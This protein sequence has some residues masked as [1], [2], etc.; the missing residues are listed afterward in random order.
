MVLYSLMPLACST[1]RV[2]I[3]S[4]RNG[5][6]HTVDSNHT[7]C[8]Q[9]LK[10]NFVAYFLFSLETQSTIGF[11]HYQ[12]T[13]QCSGSLLILAA[14]ASVGV[15]VSVFAA[16]IVLN[17][18][19][20]P[21]KRQKLMGFS[22]RAVVG[23]RDGELCLMIGIYPINA[24]KLMVTDTSI[25][26]IFLETRIEKSQ[27]VPIKC[28]E[29][30]IKNQV[31]Q[32]G[33]LIMCPIIVE[34]VID[35][36]SPLYKFLPHRG[37]LSRTFEVIV[38]IEGIIECTGIPC[39]YRTSY[40]PH[41]ILWGYRFKSPKYI[42]DEQN[43][44]LRIKGFCMDDFVLQGDRMTGLA[45]MNTNRLRTYSDWNDNRTVIC[46]GQRQ[47]KN[48]LSPFSFHKTNKYFLK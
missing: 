12:P 21:Q 3:E 43:D 38:I 2:I 9:N 5:D 39:H 40:V 32:S 29:L 4:Y 45:C 7:Q 13:N 34:H 48:L 23:H 31:H 28:Q 36:D 22:R 37:N 15:L 33:V 41:E 11:G 27:C 10:N 47:D 14:Q 24:N 6:F 46:D 25:Q 18:I 19:L 42:M 17:K 35:H 1:T 16:G 8:I 30:V 44:I 26:L 20:G